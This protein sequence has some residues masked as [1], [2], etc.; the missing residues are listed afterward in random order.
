MAMDIVYIMI[1]KYSVESDIK[2]FHEW[3]YFHEK[4]PLI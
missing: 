4:S 2:C 1:H 3:H